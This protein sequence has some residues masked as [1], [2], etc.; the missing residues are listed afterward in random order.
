M[1][2]DASTGGRLERFVRARWTRKQGGIRALATE[3]GIDKDTIYAWFRGDGEPSLS[4]LRGLANALGVPR[5]EIVYAMDGHDEAA[6]LGGTPMRRL[7]IGVMALEARDGI[8]AADLDAAELAMGVD[9]RLASTLVPPPRK[10]GG[11]VR[12]R[13]GGRAGGSKDSK[14]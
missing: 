14:S 11:R 2:L 10:L 1:A 7:L 12:G 8:S 4:A 3:A 13:T 6:P 5:G 9:A